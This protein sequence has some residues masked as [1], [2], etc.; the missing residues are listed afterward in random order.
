[1][2]NSFYLC[3]VFTMLSSTPDFQLSENAKITACQQARTIAT[4]SIEEGVDP[5]ILSALIF[6][7]SRFEPTAKSHAG[8]CGLTQVIPKYVDQTCTQLIS[9]PAL[10][11][12]VGATI[13]K[14]WLDKK[15]SSYLKG[16]QCYATG[17]KCNYP[18]YAK[19][20]IKKSKKLQKI[21]LLTQRKMNDALY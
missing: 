12:E 5:F 4:V 3:M 2:L 21:Y 16:L 18:N 6:Q 15:H 7:E 14:T 8:A 9:N 10:S 1:M 17:Y 20:I 19:R 11:I 13:L